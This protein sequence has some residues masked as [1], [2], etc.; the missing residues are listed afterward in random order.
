MTF[1]ILFYAVAPNGG[2]TIKVYVN[3][4]AQKEDHPGYDI[5]TRGVYY[6]ARLLSKQYGVEFKNQEYDKIKKVYSVWIC[7]N[8]S[9]D[10]WNTISAYRIR[11]EAVFGSFEERSRYDLL[12]VLMIRLG[13]EGGGARLNQMLNVLLGSADSKQKEKVLYDKFGVRSA[14]AIK[15]EMKVM[16]NLSEGIFEEGMEKGIIKGREEGRFST[17]WSLYKD[18]EMTFSRAL[19]K[20]NCTAEA[21]LARGKALK[22]ET[23]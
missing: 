11:H 9:P 14:G 4:E 17:I 21:F 2:K 13:K 8:A 22:E 15:E 6:C 10:K 3:I 16:C 18:G 12:E 20:T 7:M 1:D 19:E 23:I 5:V